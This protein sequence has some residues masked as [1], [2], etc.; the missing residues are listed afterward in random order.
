[1]TASDQ[2]APGRPRVARGGAVVA[3]TWLIGLG[4]ILLVRDFAGWSWTEAWPMFVML[5][6]VGMLASSIAHARRQWAGSWWLIWPVAW[7][8]V[9]F[10]LLM[11]T[12]G[13]LGVDTDDLVSQW[14]PA[15]PIGIGIWFLVASVWPGRQDPLEQV[16][17]PLAGASQARIRIRFGAGEMDV[18][19]APGGRLVSGTFVGGVSVTQ[20]GPG[21]VELEPDM[22]GWP[23]WARPLTWKF[24][25]SGEVA[26]DLRV[27]VGAARATIDLH[28][29][30][31]RRLEIKTG[32]SDTRVRLPSAA[33][34]TSVRAETGAAAMTIEVPPGVAARIRSQMALG[35]TSIDE[36]RFPRTIDGYASPDYETAANRV[37]LDLQ[38]GVGTIRIV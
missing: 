11:S 23:G 34:S 3:A 21:D 26:L 10:V 14:W 38:G 1:M 7:I 32:A 25:L 27:D 19:R 16:D 15:V 22:T 18:G 9:G 30:Q 13:R 12:T 36:T 24:G 33:G 17:L 6:G 37:E 28:D 20:R 29:L 31:V 35:T 2:P 4:T 8:G 5:V